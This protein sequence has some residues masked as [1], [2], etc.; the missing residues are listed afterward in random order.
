MSDCPILTSDVSASAKN[1]QEFALSRDVVERFM[2]IC[3][4]HYSIAIAS[5]LLLFATLRT[6]FYAVE[7]DDGKATQSTRLRTQE[8]RVYSQ[9]RRAVQGDQSSSIYC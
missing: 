1:C 4:A 3:L 2:S 8:D 7:F 9:Y 6:L 5:L